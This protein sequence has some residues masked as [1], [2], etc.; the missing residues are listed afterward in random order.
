MTYPN[1]RALWRSDGTRTQFAVYIMS[2]NSMTLYT[3]VTNDLYRR[4]QEHK[5]GEGGKFTSRY[6][7]DR[8]VY[9]ELFDLIEEAIEAEKTIKGWARAKKI[10]LIKSK[11]PQ[12]SDL[13]IFAS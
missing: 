6:H 1:Q 9:Y 2:N 12:W 7:F 11:N 4:V 5:K 3:G 8:C 13:P 10:A